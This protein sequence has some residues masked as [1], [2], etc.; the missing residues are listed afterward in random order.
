MDGAYG[1]HDEAKRMSEEMVKRHADGGPVH[2]AQVHEEHV[3]EDME[4]EREHELEGRS[5][6]A[7]VPMSSHAA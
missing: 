3:Q 5:D 6:G 1:G 7:H 4:D 2:A